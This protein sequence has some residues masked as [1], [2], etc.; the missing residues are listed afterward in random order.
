MPA[1]SESV[2]GADTFHAHSSDGGRTAGAV[3]LQGD[4][5]GQV[6]EAAPPVPHALGPPA[7][8]TVDAE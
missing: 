3:T 8:I 5:P 4:N 7:P 2:P 6:G 1:P